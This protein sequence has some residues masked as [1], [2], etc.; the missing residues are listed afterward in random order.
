MSSANESQLEEAFE[1]RRKRRSRETAIKTDPVLL[2]MRLNVSRAGYET[3]ST[4]KG[5]LTPTNPHG[6]FDSP[7]GYAI[8]RSDRSDLKYYF[9]PPV[10][11]L[12]QQIAALKRRIEKA[13]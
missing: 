5:D 12:Q 10:D 4:P 13:S 3:Q 6:R 11:V 2:Q 7:V 8:H 1:A 9:A